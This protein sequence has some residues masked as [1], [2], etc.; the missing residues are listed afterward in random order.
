MTTETPYFHCF[1]CGSLME[2]HEELFLGVCTTC[3]EARKA[4]TARV[5]QPRRP[6]LDRIDNAVLVGMLTA[7]SW[8]SYSVGMLLANPLFYLSGFACYYLMSV[9]I[10]DRHPRPLAMFA[11]ANLIIFGSVILS[12]YALAHAGMLE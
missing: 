11:F 12:F 8:A 5:R 7:L 2:P 9:R 4:S 3:D 1:G 10:L 6:L